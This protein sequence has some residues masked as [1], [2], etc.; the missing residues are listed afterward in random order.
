ML[1]CRVRAR[2]ASVCSLWNVVSSQRT[3]EATRTLKGATFAVLLLV[4][5]RTP[6]T[7]APTGYHQHATIMEVFMISCGHHRVIHRLNGIVCVYGR[8]R[9]LKSMVTGTGFSPF[10]RHRRGSKRPSSIVGTSGTTKP[11]VSSIAQFPGI[12]F[13]SVSASQQ[14]LS[15]ASSPSRYHFSL[16]PRLERSRQ[17]SSCAHRDVTD[18]H[19][20]F[21]LPQLC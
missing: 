11:S 16:P 12:F 5:S 21:T 14:T 1:T 6:S 9:A 13:A 20:T 4:T 3:V 18:F 7:A 17:S 8:G 2:C 10:H 15:S 19:A